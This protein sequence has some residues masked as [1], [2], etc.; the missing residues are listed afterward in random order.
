LEKISADVV[1]DFITSNPG[2]RY[3]NSHIA[4]QFDVRSQDSK[5]IVAEL[6]RIGKLKTGFSQKVA[7]F[8]V[9]AEAE[10]GMLSQPRHQAEFRPL[11]GYAVA[12]RRSME[13]AMGTRNQEMKEEGI[14]IS[15]I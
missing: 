9:P 14:C 13:L 5:P 8:Y 3:R 4:Q 7:V 12:L 10:V 15:K 1:L 11:E 6:V 2:K